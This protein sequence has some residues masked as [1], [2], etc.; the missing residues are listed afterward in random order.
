VSRDNTLSPPWPADAFEIGRDGRPALAGIDEGAGP[1][2]GR[3][4]GGRAAGPPSSSS[5]LPDLPSWPS[6]EGKRDGNQKVSISV[7]C[8]S[9]SQDREGGGGEGAGP[10]PASPA[11]PPRASL[12]SSSVN[13]D[14][15]PPCHRAL[16]K[17]CRVS[18]A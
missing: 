15:T 11:S 10:E 6:V 16:S 1:R 2:A 13:L 17:R 8:R 18:L 5:P 14:L 3:P 4:T 9:P 12:R 7:T